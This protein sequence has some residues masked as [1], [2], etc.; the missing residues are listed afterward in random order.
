M[1]TTLLNSK[2]AEK[3]RSGKQTLTN[4][5]LNKVFLFV[6]ESNFENAES[7]VSVIWIR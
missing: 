1:N 3:K 5:T 6:F 4:N 2:Y 7:C